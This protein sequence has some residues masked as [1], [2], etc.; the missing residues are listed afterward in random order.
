MFRQLVLIATLTFASLPPL[1]LPTA[2][3]AQTTLTQATI[4]SLRNRVRIMQRNQAARAARVTDAIRPGDGLATAAASSAAVRFNDNSLA[5]LGEQAVFQFAPGL[6]SLDLA[7][8]T[9]LMLVRPGGGNTGVRTPNAAVGIRGSAFFARYI[10]DSDTTIV[11]ALTTSGIEVVNRDATQR[12]ELKGGQMAVVVAGKIERVYQFN[13]DTFWQTSPLAQDLDWTNL[14]AVQQEISDAL[15]AQ[16]QTAVIPTL[17]NPAFVR[18][19]PSPDFPNVN[20]ATL[21]WEMRDRPTLDLTASRDFDIQS[22]LSHGEIMF[23]SSMLGRM[24]MDAMGIPSNLGNSSISGGSAIGSVGGVTSGSTINS[25][26]SNSTTTTTTNF[27]G[28]GS[29]NGVFPGGGGVFPG[30]GNG[31]QP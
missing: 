18:L 13:L 1:L 10:P 5:R 26:V 22:A 8:G 28:G 2:A 31:V 30:R 3:T 19:P 16:A 23:N 25:S 20:V 24:N 7:N 17:I 21:D 6:R 29:T 27:P 9:M 15:A 12:I 4:T 11:G 14:E